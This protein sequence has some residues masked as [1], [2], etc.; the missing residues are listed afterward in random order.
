MSWLRSRFTDCNKAN[1]T[2]FKWRKKGEWFW[3]TSSS[4]CHTRVLVLGQDQPSLAL[5][6]YSYIT[7]GKLLLSATQLLIYNI[8][9]KIHHRMDRIKLDNIGRASGTQQIILTPPFFKKFSIYFFT[10]LGLHCCTGFSL[11]VVSRGYSLVVVLGLLIAMDSPL[12]QSMG[13]LG[14]WASVS[15]SS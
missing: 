5:P 14:T 13:C 9:T 3:G 7:L 6:F 4:I 10:V 11:V 12:A 8:R 15:C 2:A 1:Q